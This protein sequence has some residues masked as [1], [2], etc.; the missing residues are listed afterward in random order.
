MGN[1]KPKKL[2]KDQIL[3]LFY[4][5][6]F[7]KGFSAEDKIKLAVMDTYIVHYDRSKYIIS[8][9]DHD[10]SV[11][12]LLKGLVHITKNVTPSL[13]IASLKPGAIFGEISFLAE[14]PRTTNVIASEHVMVLKLDR[15][16]LAQLGPELEIKIRDKLMRL[17]IAK[18]DKMNRALID[19][20]RFI[21]E[22]DRSHLNK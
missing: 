3:E 17:L 13:K 5:I 12:I 15:G 18:L 8:E 6:P 7:F 4:K 10:N 22:K 16:I 21:P 11:Y 9:G 2:S 20:V 19:Y 14:T 1:E